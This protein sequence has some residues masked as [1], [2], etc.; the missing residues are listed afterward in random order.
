MQTRNNLESFGLKAKVTPVA[1]SINTA[2]TINVKVACS[3][4]FHVR[5]TKVMAKISKTHSG[6]GVA[7]VQKCIE[8][9]LPEDSSGHGNPAKPDLQD[10]KEDERQKPGQEPQTARVEQ[11][12]HVNPPYTRRSVSIAAP[13]RL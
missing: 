10:V 5:W 8:D 13:V 12:E 9:L 3:P 4:D 6:G 7:V 1:G 2:K 11:L